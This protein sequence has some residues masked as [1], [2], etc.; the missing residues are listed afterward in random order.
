MIEKAS[1]PGFS[2]SVITNGSDGGMGEATSFLRLRVKNARLANDPFWID[3]LTPLIDTGSRGINRGNRQ[4]AKP[5][6][7]AGI[8]VY[9]YC[10][11]IHAKEFYFDRLLVG[12]ASW[13]F[14]SNSAD[15]NHEAAIFCLDT[16]LRTQIE[17]QLVLDMINSV[18]IVGPI[19]DLSV[20]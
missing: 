20:R 11:Y 2:A 18:P 5:F 7:E 15:K 17:R 13:N 9:Q 19:E 8:H 10:N 14:D 1:L 12:I 3:M 16:N 4:I 6:I